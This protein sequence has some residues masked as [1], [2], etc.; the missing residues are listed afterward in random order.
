V[1]Q[2]LLSFYLVG[3]GKNAGRDLSGALQQTGSGLKRWTTARKEPSIG[4]IY[5]SLQRRRVWL[6]AMLFRLA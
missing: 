3:N 1:R 2:V 4:K 5:R 6:A